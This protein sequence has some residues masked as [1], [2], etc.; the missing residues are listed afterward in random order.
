MDGFDKII[1][2]LNKS[3][4]VIYGIFPFF[5]LPKRKEQRKVHPW[6]TDGSESSQ[7]KNSILLPTLRAGI[8]TVEFFTLA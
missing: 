3:K 5:C 8:Q 7:A 6:G 1:I 2:F 4:G